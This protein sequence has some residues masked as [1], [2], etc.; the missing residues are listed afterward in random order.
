V[1]ITIGVPEVVAEELE[2]DGLAFSPLGGRADPTIVDAVVEVVGATANLATVVV[3][4]PAVAELSRRLIGWARAARARSNTTARDIQ[5][6][7]ATNG[8]TSHVILVSDDGDADATE[9]ADEI[10]KILITISRGD[11]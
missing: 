11:E 1:S 2:I 7:I 5:V 3:S 9:S 10:T 8:D 4:I 6:K